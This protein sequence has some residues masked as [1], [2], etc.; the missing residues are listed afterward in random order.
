MFATALC[1]K[2]L[3]RKSNATCKRNSRVGCDSFLRYCRLKRQQYKNVVPNDIADI[4][5]KSHIER[6]FT[7]GKKADELYKKYIEQTIGISAECLP[8]TSPANA[9]WS[10]EKLCEEWKI[11][12]K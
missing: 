8:S 6:I 9:V 2:I 3:M 1:L 12:Q 7:N 5:Q 4:I 10:L 11:I